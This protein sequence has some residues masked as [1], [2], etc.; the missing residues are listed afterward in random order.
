MNTAIASTTPLVSTTP[1]VVGRPRIA[2]WT[3]RIV[4][5][6]IVALLLLAAAVK[7]LA[8][9]P[10]V[11]ATRQLGYSV[12]VIRPLGLVLTLS[13][14]LYAIPRTRLL[15]AVLLTGYLGGATATHVRAGTPFWLPIVLGAILWAAYYV[16]S[17]ELRALV[18][19]TNVR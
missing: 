14:L 17:P 10:V 19:S 15:G 9:A 5:G 4:A 12:D 6:V 7:L 1:A 8:I 2:L 3:A 16:R 11:E 13:A 18:R